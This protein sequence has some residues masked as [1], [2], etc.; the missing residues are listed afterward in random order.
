MEV[1]MKRSIMFVFL[2]IFS[3]GYSTYSVSL[4]SNLISKNKPGQK[5]SSAYIPSSPS[6]NR[7]FL[8]SVIGWKATYKYWGMFH[9]DMVLY[10]TK[11]GGKTWTVIANSKNKGSTLPGGAANGMSFIS[12]VKG[13]ITA[14]SPWEGSL[15][16]YTTDDGGVTWHEQKPPVPKEFRYSDIIS[17]APLFFSNKDG[18]LFSK[19]YSEDDKQN[20]L[21]YITHNGG[22]NWIPYVNKYIGT[23]GKIKW[24]FSR[25]DSKNNK[26]I[27]NNYI[28]IFSGGF[29]GGTWIKKQY[30]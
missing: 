18:L 2:L 30:K 22:Q 6:P 28:W 3:L 1:Q 15:H 23:S 21:F 9:E 16:L 13:W 20:I 17:Y 4:K 25:V 19:P 26:V 12:P 27:Y 5:L 14:Y 8:N 7:F 29:Y 24:F 10:R 11:N